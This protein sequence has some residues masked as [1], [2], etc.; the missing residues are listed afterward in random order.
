MRLRKAHRLGLFIF[1]IFLALISF[2]LSVL[3]FPP[4]WLFV[5]LS[6]FICPDATYFVA[7]PEPLLALTLDDGPDV[8]TH[9]RTNTTNQILELLQT[10]DAHA[11]FFVLGS[12]L[13]L[14]TG[15]VLVTRMVKQGHELGNHM[16]VD[17]RSIELDPV[18]FEQT[19][20]QADR[21]LTAFAP[22]QWFRPGGGWCRSSDVQTVERYGYR[23]ALGSLWPYDTHIG[24]AQFAARYILANARPGAIIVL[25][26]GS[27]GS[28]RGKRTIETLKQVLPELHDR[29]YQIVTLSEL[30]KS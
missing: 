3:I 17:E 18:A 6:P 19:F 16:M 9:L 22:I 10:Y 25:H 28:M 29:G 5:K 26:E 27:Q 13:Q 11:T 20:L 1:G 8:S 23:V 2:G 21:A 12:R 30:I 7:T 4:P 15:Q 24:S 14:I